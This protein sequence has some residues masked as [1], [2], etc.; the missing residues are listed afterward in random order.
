MNPLFNLL[1]NNSMQNTPIGNYASFMNRFNQFRQSFNGNAEQTVNA[2][3]QSGRISQEQ[4]NNAVRQ[5]QQL[6]QML[7][8]RF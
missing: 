8:G 4:Y 6:R 2:M 1:S 5:A 7:G 3:L